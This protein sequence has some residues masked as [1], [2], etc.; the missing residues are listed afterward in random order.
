MRFRE[1]VPYFFCA[2]ISGSWGPGD[3]L[4][5]WEDSVPIGPYCGLSTGEW[6]PE[7]LELGLV[8]GAGGRWM[9]LR[10]LS[11]TG[12]SAGGDQTYLLLT[13]RARD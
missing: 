1:P 11:P 3:A 2:Q 7:C 9:G 4:G 6:P 12:L 13:D 10:P 5:H 8:G